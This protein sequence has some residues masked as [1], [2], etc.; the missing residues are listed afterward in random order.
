MTKTKKVA[1]RRRGQSASKAMLGAKV[2]FEVITGP[3]GA[4]LV[5]CGENTGFRLAGPKPC[6]VG[7]VTDRFTVDC[8]ELLDKARICAAP[9]AK[10]SGAGTASAELPG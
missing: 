6:G 10:V 5:I 8:A 4:C 7:T 3:T 2:T 9:N 1:K